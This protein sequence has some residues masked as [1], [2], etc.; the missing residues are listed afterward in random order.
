MSQQFTLIIDKDR[1]EELVLY[2]KE[3]SELAD[4]VKSVISDSTGIL[5]YDGVN[6]APLS[7]CEIY[8]IFL[9]DSKLYAMT[10]D[11]KYR[12][13]MRLYE[14]EALIGNGFVKI[15]Q[16]CIANIK[17]IDRFEVSFAGA[18]SVIFK[19]G[20]KDYISRRQLKKVKERIGF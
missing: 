15:N 19:N 11:K 7:P 6:V 10:R 18:L 3:K 5:G 17:R 8:A 1:E 16:S 9:E 12:L 14:A 13:K 2:L 4:R 20:Y